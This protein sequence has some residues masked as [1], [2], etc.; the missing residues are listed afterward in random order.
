[1]TATLSLAAVQATEI[2]VVVPV[3]FASPVGTLGAVV[4]VGQALVEA[5]RLA[6][7]ERLAAASKASTEKV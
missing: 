3:V 5:V 1:M 7:A 4:S 2:E 6:L